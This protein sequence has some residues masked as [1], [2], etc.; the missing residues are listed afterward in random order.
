MSA[1][2]GPTCRRGAEPHT[3][4][5]RAPPH[6]PSRTAGIWSTD[7]A[8]VGIP[9]TSANDGTG[10]GCS[11]Q[12]VM[13]LLCEERV[14]RRSTQDLATV[15]LRAVSDRASLV[16]PEG[17]VEPWRH[18][19]LHAVVAA[20][21]THESDDRHLARGPARGRCRVRGRSRRFCRSGGTISRN[22]SRAW[23][24]APSGSRRTVRPSNQDDLNVL[25][26][27]SGSAA[28][29]A[30]ATWRFAAAEPFVRTR[31]GGRRERLHCPV[32][33]GGGPTWMSCRP[34]NIRSG[35]TECRLCWASNR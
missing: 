27:G 19:P 18:A 20:P 13:P 31:T 15:R 34:M 28:P 4:L 6:A 12:F 9:Q 1:T 2:P 21:V 29:H 14:P 30:G 22:G 23:W 7:R 16:T 17:R 25:L 10:S 8:A 26:A 5:F 24:N 35:A 3:E 11:L 32:G 33:T